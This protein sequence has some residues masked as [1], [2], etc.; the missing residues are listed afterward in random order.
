MLPVGFPGYRRRL[1]AGTGS[2]LGRE[3]RET[4]YVVRYVLR[5][6]VE[7]GVITVDDNHAVAL[8]LLCRPRSETGEGGRDSRYVE[9]AGLQRRVTPWL[10]VRRE[11][12]HIHTDEQVVVGLAEKRV[13]PVEVI[14]HKDHTHIAVAHGR[15][16]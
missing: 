4:Q 12:R 2:L 10:V 16:I 15:A 11:D 14:G 6:L 3:A 9:G 8:F 5:Y 1:F 7:V 13:V